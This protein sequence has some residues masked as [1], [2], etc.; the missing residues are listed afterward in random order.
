MA[1]SSTGDVVVLYVG[2]EESEVARGL[3][4]AGDLSVRTVTGPTAALA[5]LGEADCLVCDDAHPE[6]NAVDLVERVREVESDFPLVALVT[7]PDDAARVVEAGATD[8]LTVGLAAASVETLVER[9][10]SAVAATAAGPTLDSAAQYRTLVE[11]SSDIVTVVAPDGTIVY[12]S[13][14]VERILGWDPDELL[15]D[16]VYNHVHPADKG[17]IRGEFTELVRADEGDVEEFEHRFER[18]DGT[19]AWLETV[20]SNRKHTDVG[21][22]VFNSRDI[23]GRHERETELERER[24]LL[25]VSLDTIEEVFYLIDDEG[26]LLRWND[27]LVSV[28]GYTETELAG[29][30]SIE[31]FD[32]ADRDRVRAAAQEAFETGTS[33][34]EASVVTTDGERVPFEFRG[35]RFS[36]PAGEME[37]LVGIGRDISDRRRRHEERRRHETIV[38]ATPDE[39][40]TLDEEGNLTSVIPPA[41]SDVSVTGY[42]PEALLGEHVSKVMDEGDVAAGNELVAGLLEDDERTR[43]CF[44]MD[45]VTKSGERIPFENH[46]A[47][48][49]SDDGEFR[50]TV[51]VLRDISERKERERELEKAETSF[52]NSQDGIFLVDVTDDRRFVVERVNPAYE[53]MSGLDA[54]AVEGKTPREILGDEV[55]NR[56]EARFSECVQR[57]TTLSY[58]ETLDVP[59]VPTHWHTRISPVVVD[60]RV[61]QIVGSTRDV[62]ERKEREHRLELRERAMAEAPIGITIAER[63]ETGTPIVYANGGFERLTGYDGT[64]IT[65]RNWTDL[66]GAETDAGKRRELAAAVEREDPTSVELVCYRKDGT[67]FW[68]RTDIAPVAFEGEAVTHYIG[69]QQDV[70]EAKEYEQWIE[71]RFDEFGEVL[72]EDLGGPLEEV[73]THLQQARQNGD[74]DALATAEE[75]LD[76]VETLLDDLTT[77]HSFNVKDRELSEATLKGVREDPDGAN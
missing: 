55:G 67:P 17:T 41:D 4:A 15:G 39:V 32:E 31:F 2:A 60:G 66:T 19:W 45:L 63:R 58:E 40:Y 72:A 46:V 76:R 71:R 10:E 52:Q 3:A 59:D 48:L 64:E 73:R 5:A 35:V 25:A 22:Y 37:G 68:C 53:A 42:D 12:Q 49:P 36:D 13:P 57:Q 6:T 30:N 47:L 74:E 50:G 77:V 11:H 54:A 29:M 16:S 24:E 62:T 7:D 38:R 56:I 34:V 44:E 65:G 26:E 9:V 51:G 33:T 61:E 21:G 27:S 20:G 75:W 28:T 70:T 18:A 14:S 23:S 1:A 8:C 69:F 43:D